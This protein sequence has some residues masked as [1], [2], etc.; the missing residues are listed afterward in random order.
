MIKKWQDGRTDDIT[1][2]TD[3][4]KQTKRQ[5]P[6]DGQRNGEEISVIAR[7]TEKERSH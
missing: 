4:S 1:R 7:V 2:H 6:V 3:R 5:I